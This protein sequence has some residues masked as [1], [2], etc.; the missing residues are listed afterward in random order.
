MCEKFAKKPFLTA[1]G[2][3]VQKSHQGR[4]TS[5]KNEVH[6]F[7]HW[8]TRLLDSTSGRLQRQYG[9]Q[10]DSIFDKVHKATTT[11]DSRCAY[12]LPGLEDS[13]LISELHQFELPFLHFKDCLLRLP[14]RYM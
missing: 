2:L 11:T 9:H 3:A 13:S 8:I 7:G 5:E 12:G 1:V 14:E 6:F 4:P 10:T